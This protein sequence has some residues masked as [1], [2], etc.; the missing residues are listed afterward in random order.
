MFASLQYIHRGGGLV[1]AGT[2]GRGVPFFF[3]FFAKHINSQAVPMGW[4]EQSRAC[5]GRKRQGRVDE[6][7]LLL[8]E[9]EGSGLRWERGPR[10]RPSDGGG[11]MPHSLLLP[12]QQTDRSPLLIP[13]LK[14]KTPVTSKQESRLVMFII[15]SVF[16]NLQNDSWNSPSTYLSF[17]IG[18]WLF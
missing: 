7:Y 4:G 6:Q 15:S 17:S 18:S 14:S 10:A 5:F 13:T 16:V 1:Q 11:T 2:G 9:S 8:K 3:F 12:D